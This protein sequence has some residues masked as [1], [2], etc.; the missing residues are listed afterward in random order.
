MKYFTLALIGIVAADKICEVDEES[1]TCKDGWEW[2]ESACACFT[3]AHC[4]I[5]CPDNQILSPLEMCNC[6][7]QCEYDE[8]FTDDAICNQA[9][10]VSRKAQAGETC[11]GFN[12]KTGEPFPSCDRGLECKQTCE[13][14]IPGACNTCVPTDITEPVEESAG[15]FDLSMVAIYLV[16]FSL[17]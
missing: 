2:N 17:M 10:S 11:E 4:K 12:E 3:R 5:M 13:F 6:I 14:S 8:M 9:K 15:L 16:G 1:K 7:D